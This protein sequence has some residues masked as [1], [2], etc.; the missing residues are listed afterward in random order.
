MAPFMVIG[1]TIGRFLHIP[2]LHIE[3]EKSDCISCGKCSKSC[4]MGLDVKA[5]VSE[6]KMSGCSE[7]INCG[8]CIDACPKKVIKYKFK[9]E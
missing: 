2:Q 1:S 6:G 7:C 3:A 8:A 5:M 9:W 4:P